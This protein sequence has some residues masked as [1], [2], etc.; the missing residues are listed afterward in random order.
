MLKIQKLFNAVKPAAKWFVLIGLILSTNGC[1]S[2]FLNK[3]TQTEAKK[4]TQVTS[5]SGFGGTGKTQ[6]TSQDNIAK[7]S[8]FG[9]TGIIGTITEFGSIL[10]NGIKVEYSKDLKIQSNLGTT[11]KLRIGQQVV[12]ETVIDKTLP[13]ADKIEVFYPLAGRIEEVHQDYI[14][15]DK[16]TVFISKSTHIMDNLQL[17]IGH[18]VAINGYPN[19]DK[20]W[21]A[22]LISHNPEK[23]HFYK[24]LPDIK[25]SK[26]LRK[27]SIQSTQSQ[28]KLWDEKFGGLPINLI[29]TSSTTTNFLIDADIRNGEITQ[30][31]LNQ[32]KV[33]INEK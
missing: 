31:Q 24:S 9:G 7:N 14:V 30:Y 27:L 22:T 21:N 15:V 18:Y 28:L 16:H 4:Q 23:K 32:Y 8:G 5:K 25:F 13:W 1:Q 29:M 6:N 19:L 2:P 10:V 11:D 12:L 26:N 17:A 33:Q 3:P 20:S